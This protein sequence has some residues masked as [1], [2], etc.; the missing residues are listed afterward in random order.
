V[1]LFW[2]LLLTLGAVLIHGLGIVVITRALRLK[3]D[4]LRRT[5]VGLEAFLLLCAVALAV[6]VLHSL[7]IALFA[8]FYATVGLLPDFGDALYYSAAVFSTLGAP[9][10]E[11]HADWRLV[12]AIEGLA[13]ILL[14]GWS[15]A[16]FVTDMNILLREHEG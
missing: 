7:E 12:G 10:F 9:E 6:F 4:R 15:A 16:F 11:L 1:Q 8:A 2:G 3:E 13:G 14:L 5:P